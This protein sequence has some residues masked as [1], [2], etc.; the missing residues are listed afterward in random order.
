MPIS[1][2]CP[3][4]HKHTELIIARAEY[5]VDHRTYTTHAIWKVDDERQW[6]IGVC[7][8]CGQPCLVLNTGA[9]IFPSPLPSPTDKNIPDDLAHD[10]NEAKMCFSVECYRASAVMARR[11]I[12]NACLMKGAAKDAKLVEQ[13]KELK[14]TGVITSDLAEWATV[15]RWVGNDAAHPGG[16]PV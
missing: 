16:D 15:V 9:T 13:I 12:Q 14:N 2:F 6:W 11:S 10:L 7:N 3:H 4:C 5:E 8:A 1:I